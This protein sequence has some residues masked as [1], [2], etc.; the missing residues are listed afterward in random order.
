M[1]TNALRSLERGKLQ[2]ACSQLAAFPKVAT[3][4]VRAGAWSQATADAQIAEVESIRAQ[5]GCD[6][7]IGSPSGAFLDGCEQH[8]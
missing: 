7:P 5:L 3:A 1:L 4:K 2:P 6:A 8:F